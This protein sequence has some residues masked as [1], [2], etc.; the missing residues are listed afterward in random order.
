MTSTDTGERWAALADLDGADGWSADRW[1]DEA[2]PYF[3]AH[4]AIAI[5]GDARS[6]SMLLIDEHPDHWAVE[7]ILAD[8]DDE[9]AWRIVARVDLAASDE[10]GEPVVT[11]EGVVER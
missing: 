5:D 6:A 9:H 10:V 3:V 7:Q 8:R 4:D 1:H 11:V 2:A